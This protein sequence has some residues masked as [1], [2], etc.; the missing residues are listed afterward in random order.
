MIPHSEITS[1]YYWVVYLNQT[2]I[3]QV[4]NDYGFSFGSN[5]RVSIYAFDFICRIEKPELG[6]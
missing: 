5:E 1:G 4:I 6:E 3:V 2:M